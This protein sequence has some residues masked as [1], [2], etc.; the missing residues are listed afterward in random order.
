MNSNDSFT[1]ERL[2]S[3]ISGLEAKLDDLRRT[4]EGILQNLDHQENA[5]WSE[6]LN[7]F[8]SATHDLAAI[9][10][11]TR[12][13]GF[14]PSDDDGN[15]FLRLQV[16]VPRN[17]CPDV[18]PAL[19]EMTQGRLGVFDHDA[20]PLYM[21]TK[22]NP[23]TESDEQK[24]EAS[25]TGEERAY[26]QMAV[27]SKTIEQLVIYLN[28]QPSS[29]TSLMMSRAQHINRA[30]TERLARAVNNGEGL[31]PVRANLVHDYASRTSGMGRP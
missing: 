14:F 24:V 5:S 26:R 9:Q 16:V 4:I 1:A 31:E 17:I 30:T 11:M 25:F 27:M 19:A 8:K 18:D 20:L 10:M 3:L 12:R 23:E 22:H 7:K 21:R 28:E 2:N 13:G 29:S 15:D 6:I